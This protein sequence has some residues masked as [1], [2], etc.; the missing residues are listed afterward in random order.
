ME[1]HTQLI[2][3]FPFQMPGPLRG[4][5][6]MGAGGNENQWHVHNIGLGH[7]K[8]GELE[9]FDLVQ[10][11]NRVNRA[12]FQEAIILL[13][14]QAN[15]VARLP[16]Y[17][18]LKATLVR[19]RDGYG[20]APHW[21]EE[22]RD[23]A[24]RYLASE[25]GQCWLNQERIG[26]TDTPSIRYK[27]SSLAIQRIHAHAGRNSQNDDDDADKHQHI[28]YRGRGAKREPSTEV[29]IVNCRSLRHRGEGRGY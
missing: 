21:S 25:E 20:P 7:I 10:N 5:E 12:T 9:R 1:L 29:H 8:L 3:L 15:I 17:N 2:L 14:S 23:N 24:D 26:Y 22:A 19:L 13:D 28:V 16:N 11:N 18:D 6:Y 27:G 4:P